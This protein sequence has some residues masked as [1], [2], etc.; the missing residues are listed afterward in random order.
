[1]IP[2]WRLLAHLLRCEV[3]EAVRRHGEAAAEACAVPYA[4]N[5]DAE[6][7]RCCSQTD[8]GE[9]EARMRQAAVVPGRAAGAARMET[10]VAAGL[11]WDRKEAWRSVRWVACPSCQAEE[12]RWD[13]VDPC[14]REDRGETWEAARVGDGDA[15]LGVRG[16][17]RRGEDKTDQD[18]SLRGKWT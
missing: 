6:E 13:R 2:R 17:G 18:R 1:M 16:Q 4:E 7:A 3:G 11:D 14:R 9:V 5:L 8:G 10:E 15:C 12:D